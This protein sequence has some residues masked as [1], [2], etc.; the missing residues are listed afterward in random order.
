MGADGIV[1]AVSE[2]VIWFGTVE[3]GVGHLHRIGVLVNTFQRHAQSFTIFQEGGDGRWCGAVHVM[4]EADG[5]LQVDAGKHVAVVQRRTYPVAPGV[6][7]D[8]TIVFTPA[9]GVLG[10]GMRNTGAAGQRA[11]RRLTK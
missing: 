3:I 11:D 6:A 5:R 8:K 7:R 10:R 4:T 9:F 2:L 1:I